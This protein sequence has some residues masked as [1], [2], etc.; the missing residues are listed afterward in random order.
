MIHGFWRKGDSDHAL[1]YGQHA[2]ALTAAGGDVHEQARAQS[3][4]GTVYFSLGDYRLAIDV[5][6][7]SIASLEGKLRHTLHAV[8]LTAVRSRAWLIDCLR[9]LGKFA[10]GLACGET[11]SRI[12]EA[13]G[14]LSRAI[15]TQ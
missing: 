12:A 1:A 4:V 8:M 14:H 11:A 7:R 15:Y 5:F 6:R 10:E 9:E 2:L 13:A 3:L